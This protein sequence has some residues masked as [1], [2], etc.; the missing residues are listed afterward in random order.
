MGVPL[1]NRHHFFS[2]FFSLF[3]WLWT[4]KKQKGGHKIEIEMKKV[5]SLSI[6]RLQFFPFWRRDEKKTKPFFAPLFSFISSSW[7]RIL[8]SC[9]APLLWTWRAWSEPGRRKPLRRQKRL[10]QCRPEVCSPSHSSLRHP[11]LGINTLH[12]STIC[13]QKIERNYKMEIKKKRRCIKRSYLT[14]KTCLFFV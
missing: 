6:D 2:N 13:T 7:W 4:W 3:F 9:S 5:A 8:A 1:C 10:R 12:R 11:W 14:R